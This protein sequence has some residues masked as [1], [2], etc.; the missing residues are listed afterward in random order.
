MLVEETACP[1]EK[2]FRHKAAW[3]SPII[4]T[5][6]TV[7]YCRWGDYIENIVWCGIMGAI[8][9]FSIRGCI[10]AVHEK[11]IARRNFHITVLLLIAVEYCLWTASCYWVSDTLSNPYFWFD[12]ALTAVTALLLPVVEKAVRE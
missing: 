9:W 6:L 1:Q 12:F 7:F 11:N 2:T 8:G 10:W 5:A 3:I 4:S